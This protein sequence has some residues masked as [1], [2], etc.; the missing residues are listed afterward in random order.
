MYDFLLVR[1]CNCSF[2]WYRF[3]VIWRW[4]ISWPWNLGLRSLKVIQTGTIQKLECDF[5]FAF[6]SNYGSILSLRMRNRY[7]VYFELTKQA[8]R[9]FSRFWPLC[10]G[11]NAASAAGAF[12]PSLA[13]GCLRAETHQIGMLLLLLLVLP[14]IEYI[15][16]TWCVLAPTSCVQITACHV[17][18]ISSL[19][20]CTI[21][22]LLSQ[23]YKCC[24]IL[25][26]LWLLLLLMWWMKQKHSCHGEIGRC[27]GFLTTFQNLS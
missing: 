11:S 27:T 4:V 3:W 23:S 22:V 15:S 20:C 16:S 14:T 18:Q 2:I 25:Q 21:A 6:Y 13:F 5:L 7:L 17:L 10:A 24:V 19:R 1:H 9:N 8:R 12:C 26:L